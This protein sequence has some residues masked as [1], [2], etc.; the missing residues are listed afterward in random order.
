M[1]IYLRN[2]LQVGAKVL[3]GWFVHF[4]MLAAYSLGHLL[5]SPLRRHTRSYTFHR[6][7]D[8]LQYGSG[9]DYHYKPSPAVDKQQAAE[10]NATLAAAV[11]AGTA[12]A[13]QEAASAG[14]TEQQQQQWRQRVKVQSIVHGGGWQSPEVVSHLGQQLRYVVAAGSATAS[15]EE[16]ALAGAHPAA[17]AAGVVAAAA[18]ATA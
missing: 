2:C 8:A 1:T 15:Q 18:G 10:L 7:C 4:T 13:V 14:S 17:A 5:L 6:L 9:S 3:L 11:A 16:E 12:A